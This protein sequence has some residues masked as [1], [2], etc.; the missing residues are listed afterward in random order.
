ME[1]N[2]I[3]KALRSFLSEFPN[4]RAAD[5]RE[6]AK[7]SQN[8]SLGS[9]TACYGSWNKALAKNGGN[10][11]TIGTQKPQTYTDD[12]LLRLGQRFFAT[13]QSSWREFIRFCKDGGRSAN[14]VMLRWDTWKSFK[15]KV[16]EFDG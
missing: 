13:G 4:G 7:T 16:Q 9:V 1:K 11:S 2:I 8:P 12:D 15:A 3:D 5:Y 6:W 10:T 14:I